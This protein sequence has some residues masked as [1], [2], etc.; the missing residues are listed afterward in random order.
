MVD[1]TYSLDKLVTSYSHALALHLKHMQDATGEVA[2]S[3]YCTI[4][5]MLNI[6]HY[7]KI[8]WKKHVYL[9]Y[10]ELCLFL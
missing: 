9:I 6:I 1:E 8:T 10:N 4:K 5:I 2:Q 3:T 7:R